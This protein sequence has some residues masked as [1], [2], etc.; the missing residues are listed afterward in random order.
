MR[1]ILL[2]E[3]HPE[4]LEVLAD[5]LRDEGYVVLEAACGRHAL[6]LAASWNYDIHAAII[7]WTLP[8]M[9]GGEL[10][11]QLRLPV[12]ARALFISGYLFPKDALVTAPCVAKPFTARDLRRYLDDPLHF[13]A[14]NRT[15]PC[16]PFSPLD[17]AA[18]A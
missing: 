11:R 4:V 6:S 13:P 5:G 7:D 18:A 10:L 2:V 9:T 1:K 16:L 12:P 15:R 17:A 3:D 14:P 8:D